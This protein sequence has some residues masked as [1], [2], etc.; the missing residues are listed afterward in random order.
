[1]SSFLWKEFIVRVCLL[2]VPDLSVDLIV[3]NHLVVPDL[4]V[5]LIVDNHLVVPDLSVDFIV[6]NHLA[7]FRSEC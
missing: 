4:S 1:M 3:D 2:A 6:N 5:D 7:V